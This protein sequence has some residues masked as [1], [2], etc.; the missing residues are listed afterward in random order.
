MGDHVVCGQQAARIRQLFVLDEG[1]E[2]R[3]VSE[4]TA[5]QPVRIVGFSDS[6]SSGERVL[7]ATSE[8]HAETVVEARRNEE[9]AKSLQEAQEKRVQ[10]ERQR[11]AAKF[12]E[13]GSK[14]NTIRVKGSGNDMI[15]IELESDVERR[16]YV[17]CSRTQ[18]QQIFDELHTQVRGHGLARET[19]LYC[20]ETETNAEKRKGG[21][22]GRNRRS[23]TS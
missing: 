10:E 2:P 8:E 11:R 16:A 19:G 13:D 14:K 9:M 4:A 5:G 23:G 3:S 22:G 12:A 17:L 6:I 1:E 20:D 7:T 15:E 18:P 21:T